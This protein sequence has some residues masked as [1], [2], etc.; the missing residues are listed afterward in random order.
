MTSKSRKKED[1][2]P[3]RTARE[4]SNKVHRHEGEAID[5][6][7]PANPKISQML[8]AFGQFFVHDI[9]KTPDGEF[10]LFS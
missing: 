1:L 3:L 9:I 6:V 8:W 5:D 7:T 10:H 2:V 4:I